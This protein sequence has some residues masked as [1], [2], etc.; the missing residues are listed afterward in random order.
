MSVH[1]ISDRLLFLEIDND[2]R[3]HLKEFLPI[4]DK[5][6]PAIMKEFY[7]HLRKRPHLASIFGSGAQQEKAMAHAAEAQIKH[8]NNLFSG[9]FDEQYVESVRKIGLTHSRIGLEPQWYI[10]GYAFILSRAYPLIAHAY[11]SRLNPAAAQE[12]TSRMLR[13]V[14]QAVMLD[15]DMAI[16][17]YIQENKNSYEQKLEKLAGDFEESVKEVVDA[18]T[19][20]AEEMRTSAHTLTSASVETGQQTA[21]VAAATE[22]ASAN[23]QAVASATEELTYSSREI[24]GQ[25]EK[26]SRMAQ[27][28]ATETSRTNATVDELFRAAQ[29]IGDVVQLIQQVASQTNLLA[30]N[31]T[32][33]AARAGD[34]GKGFAVVASEVKQLA[35]QTARATEEIATQINGIQSTTTET[36]AAIQRIGE[37]I[38]EINVVSATIANAVQ[39]QTLAIDEISN[40]VQQVSQGTIEI[41]SS[42]NMVTQSAKKNGETADHVLNMSTRLSG[43][44]AQLKNEV[45]KFL[46]TLRSH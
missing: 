5:V 16:S 34:A 45:E 11:S 43:Q 10:G 29:K 4:I 32:I 24:G 8:W 42:I 38:N 31:A 14:N 3:S 28:G 36:V 41:S 44:A 9:K 7:D 40:N 26:S 33:E 37:T 46:T 35:N 1:D 21:T 15:M 17:I 27:Q 30:L 25:M 6:L 20:S 23:M 19:H 12:K 2:T 22:E 39:E 18:V 13:A